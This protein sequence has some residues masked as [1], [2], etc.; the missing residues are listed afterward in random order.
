LDLSGTFAEAKERATER[1]EA[2]YLHGL[3]S[4]SKGNLSLAS[5]S[6]DLARN[7]LRELLKKRGLY[8]LSWPEDLPS[9]DD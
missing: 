6:A 4:R 8:G 5:R 1:F 7:H 3:M 9:E 2:A